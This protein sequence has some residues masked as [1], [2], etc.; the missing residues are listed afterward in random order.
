MRLPPGGS[1]AKRNGARALN[2]SLNDFQIPS[3]PSH[4][5]TLLN[6]VK[7]KEPARV[8]GGTFF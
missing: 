7:L 1:V 2:D 5:E 8:M 3:G 4:S 6:E